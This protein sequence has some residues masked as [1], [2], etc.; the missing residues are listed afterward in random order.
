MKD[1]LRHGEL[2]DL[3]GDLKEKTS[4]DT[5]DDRGRTWE[6][7]HRM[8][9]SEIGWAAKIGS[10]D[11]LTLSP[12]NC[13]LLSYIAMEKTYFKSGSSP[14]IFTGLMKLAGI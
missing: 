11:S 6:R 14:E 7:R 2:F 5:R 8:N 10:V 13:P 9:K 4:S 3:E 12:I 1:F